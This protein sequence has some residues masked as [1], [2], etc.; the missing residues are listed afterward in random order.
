[1]TTRRRFF[2]TLPFLLFIVT[3]VSAQQK[4]RTSVPPSTL[5][6][7]VKAE[8]H[9]RWDGDLLML[10]QSSNAAVRERAALAAGRIGNQGAIPELASLLVNDKHQSVRATAAFAIGEIESLNGTVALTETLKSLDET[11]TVRARAIEGLGKI[12]AALPREQQTRS[13][14]IGNIV[15]VALKNEAES[16]DPNREFLLLGITAVLRSRPTGGGAVLASLLDHKDGRVR[17]DAANALARLRVKDANSKLLELLKDDTDPNVRANAARVLGATEDK[18]AFEGL[19]KA[20]EDK[21][22]RVRVNAI[23]ALV[24]LKDDRAAEIVLKH[25]KSIT[26]RHIKTKLPTELNELLEIATALG[27]LLA[28]K[29]DERALDWINKGRI[30]LDKSAPELELAYVRISPDKYLASFGSESAIAK[31]SLQETTILRWRS[32]AAIAQA[33]GEIATLPATVSNKAELSETAQSY[34]RAMLNYKNS[35]I[36]INSLLPLHSEYGIPDI[37]RAYASF[38]PAD[39]SVVLKSGLE[40]SDVMVRATSADLL[41]NLPPSDQNTNLLLSALMRAYRDQLNDAI[42]STLSALGKQRNEK[43]NQALKT[44]LESRE[45]LIQQRAANLL[46]ENNQGDYSSKLAPVWTPNADDDYRR[47]LA[48]VGKSVRAVVTTTKG[49]FT[50]AL[51]PDEAPLTVDNFVQLA[52]KGYYRNIV[53][54]R[55]IPNFVIQGGDPRSDGNG[56]PGY[57]IRCEVNEVPYDRGAVGMALSGKDT[58]GSQWFVTHAPQPHLDGGFTVFGRVVSGMNVVDAIV[59]GDTIRSITIR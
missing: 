52:R 8:D 23:R 18:S 41:G 25:G 6:R 43:S 34:L 33:L 51:L 39:L 35:D 3:S 24:T 7:I 40:D 48:R 15:L 13:A 1:M 31:R 5:L 44:A 22:S 47:A 59:R 9:R 46:K 38:K 12:A 45:Y 4:S 30:E 28:L 26:D 55:V 20:L 37:L 49:S 57:A 2:I 36:K 50:I 53:F 58:G 17:S 10:M 11:D 29:A 54:H 32:A 27:R 56:G 42:L 21:D 16:Q 14:E 19:V